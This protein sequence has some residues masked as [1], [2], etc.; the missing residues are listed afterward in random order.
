MMSNRGR[1]RAD[2]RRGRFVSRHECQFVSRLPA[3]EVGVVRQAVDQ[4]AVIEG[5]CP[6][7]F[8]PTADPGHKAMRFMFTLTGNAPQRVQ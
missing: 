4:L 8:G 3:D 2:P 7:M 6:C 1:F 5:G